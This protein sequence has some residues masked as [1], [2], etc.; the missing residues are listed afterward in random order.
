M[1]LRGVTPL[2]MH[3]PQMVDKDN[4]IV[5]LIAK[6]TDKSSRNQTEEDRAEIQRLEFFG[7]LYCSQDGPYLPVAN[8]QGCLI[9]AAKARRLG[10]TMNRALSPVGMV[11][12][13]V[14]P[15]PRDPAMLWADPQYRWLTSVGVG[16]KRV[17]RMRPQFPVWELS[18][19]F[20]LLADVL[21]LADLRDIANLAGRIEGLGD[22][23]KI[24]R[25]R[26]VV[27][28]TEIVAD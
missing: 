2:A 20:E 1:H 8:V 4:E 13:L 9:S 22:G 7:G 14:Y 3:N 27:E 15:G 16:A 10:T 17:M 23:R 28:V 21:D 18:V 6:I 5:K 12:P 19:D 24:G 11:V 26:F 25:G